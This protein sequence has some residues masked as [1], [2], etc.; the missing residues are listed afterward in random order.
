MCVT[1]DRG[2][3]A[4]GVSAATPGPARAESRGVVGEVMSE[5]DL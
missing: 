5:E 4:G 2:I 1:A 3:R